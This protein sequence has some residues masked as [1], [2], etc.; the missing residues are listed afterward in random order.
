MYR[1]KNNLKFSIII[2]DP[3]AEMHIFALGHRNSTVYEDA[4]SSSWWI[5]ISMIDILIVI[6]QTHSGLIVAVKTFSKKYWL[7]YILI[8]QTHSGS[9]W[10][11]TW[12]HPEFGQVLASCSFDRTV[13]I[14]EE[15]GKKDILRWLIRNVHKRLHQQEWYSAKTN[16]PSNALYMAKTSEH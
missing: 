5:L 11:V 4:H 8:I 9:V 6:P 14:W 10:K 2:N 12:A 7:V 16:W 15:Q 1:W 13:A 3:S